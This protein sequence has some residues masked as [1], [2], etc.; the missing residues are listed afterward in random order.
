M[1]TPGPGRRAERLL[2][3]ARAMRDAGSPDAAL[4]LLVAVE[5]GPLDGLQTAQVEHLRGQIAF[6]QRRGSD[7][8][9]LLPSA[10]RRL[11]PFDAGLARETHLE[12]LV[13][14]MWAGDLDTPGGLRE[15][16]EAA[17]R[18]PRSR[19]AAPDGRLARRV[20]TVAHTGARCGGL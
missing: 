16:A 19:S 11:E 8:A 20:R 3:A 5:A 10:A 17:R 7:A 4:G 12:S 13:A 14:T 2:A 6:D 9:R 1:L 15:A 18:A